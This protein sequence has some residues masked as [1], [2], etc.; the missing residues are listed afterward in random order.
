MEPKMRRVLRSYARSERGASAVELAFALFLLTIPI[1]NVVDL[2]FYAFNWMQTQNAAQM[3]AQA[4]FSNCNSAN[5][6]PAATNCYGAYN[7]ADNLT[8]YDVVT[9][10]IQE[11]ALNS[12][13]AVNNSVVVDGYYCSTTSNVL[14]QVGNL[15]YA[16]PDTGGLNAAYNT[17][18]LAP[19]NP[20]N[21]TTNSA[22]CGAGYA[23][24]SASPGEYIQ[25]TVRHTYVPIF[26]GM[27][28]VALLPATMM[29]TAWARLN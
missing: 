8:L 12:S 6:L 23:D 9:Q 14:T 27:T 16:Y 26:P 15:G 21:T 3:G 11:S 25:V 1:L 18:D 4:A 10:G 17:A 28:V 19:F 20:V 2:A 7:S 13:V 5:T 22:A 24:T 29:A